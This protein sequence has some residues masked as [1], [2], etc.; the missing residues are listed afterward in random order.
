MRLF[1]SIGRRARTSLIVFSWPW[2]LSVYAMTRMFPAADCASR[3]RRGSGSNAQYLH[4][5]YPPDQRMRCLLLQKRPPCFVWLLAAFLG[6]HSNTVLCIYRTGTSASVLSARL[7]ARRRD[8]LIRM[9]VLLGLR[10]R[11]SRERLPQLRRLVCLK[12]LLP[13]RIWKGDS[14][15]GVIR[16]ALR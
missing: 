3:K 12:P 6:S 2:L 8:L 4:H 9:H 16:Y 10:R 14:S 5:Q 11:D 13:S 7:S 1:F 15:P